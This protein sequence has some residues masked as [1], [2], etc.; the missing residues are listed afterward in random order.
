[1]IDRA[2][3]RL[4]AH[5]L[6]HLRAVAQGIAPGV[7][8]RRYLLNARDDDIHAQDRKSVLHFWF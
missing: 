2:P 1:M 5:V 6:A 8:S 4:S 3:L 7:A